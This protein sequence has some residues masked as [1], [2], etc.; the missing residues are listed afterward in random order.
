MHVAV[1]SDRRLVLEGKHLPWWVPAAY[2]GGIFA[3]LLGGPVI[4][5]EWAAIPFVFGC[6]GPLLIGIPLLVFATSS[7][8]RLVIDSGVAIRKYAVYRLTGAR[9]RHN[10]NW[11]AIRRVEAK[12]DV[13]YVGRYRVP[14]HFWKLA[15]T[16]EGKLTQV[17]RMDTGFGPDSLDGSLAI[18]RELFGDR[19]AVVGYDPSAADRVT[20]LSGRP[21]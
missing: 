3:F 16:C 7:Y 9:L 19:L 8:P 6:G 21:G 15:V 4:R 17:G 2:F 13:E 11:E 10:L 14:N 20:P 18:L 1:R 12:A 5:G